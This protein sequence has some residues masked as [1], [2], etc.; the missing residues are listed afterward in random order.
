MY[1]YE[2]NEASPTKYRKAGRREETAGSVTVWK[3]T[4][5]RCTAYVV[6]KTDSTTLTPLLIKG[7]GIII[8][9]FLRTVKINSTTF[10]I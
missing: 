4:V 10:N 7:S 3:R 8:F 5:V 9:F 1:A 6:L 2:P